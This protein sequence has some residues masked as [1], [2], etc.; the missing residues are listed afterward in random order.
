GSNPPSTDQGDVGLLESAVWRPNGP[1]GGGQGI[2]NEKQRPHLAFSADG[3][4]LLSAT[5][6]FRRRA[7]ETG[8]SLWDVATGRELRG[9]QPPGQRRL[10][11]SAALSLDGR[12][13]AL[14]DQV[15]RGGGDVHLIDAA[16]GKE[17]HRLRAAGVAHMAVNQRGMVDSF[18]GVATRF[19]F[20]PDGRTL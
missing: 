15:P 13:V 2:W 20:A 7:I 5:F 16:T 4:T 14:V 1:G 17:L 3:K 19:A 8:V 10:A 11:V 6:G 9:V 12:T 18:P